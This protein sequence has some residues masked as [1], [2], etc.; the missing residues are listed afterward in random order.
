[1]LEVGAV[2][3]AGG[4]DDD[5]RVGDAARRRG[6]QG[7]EQPLTGRIRWVANDSGKTC[8]IARRF[9]ST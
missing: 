1:V 6:A 5:R 4:E 3:D 2:V 8:V 9:A 7:G